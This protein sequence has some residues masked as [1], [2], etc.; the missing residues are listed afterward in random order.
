MYWGKTDCM[1][2]DG[3]IRALMALLR[4][5]YHACR[6]VH[7]SSVE[8][9]SRRRQSPNASGLLM[10]SPFLGELN[11]PHCAPGLGAEVTGR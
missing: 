3:R 9:D 7:I 8:E 2:G 4:G 5:E 6:M 11:G 1:D 10:S